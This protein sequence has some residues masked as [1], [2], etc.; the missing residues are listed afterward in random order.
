M[1]IPGHGPSPVGDLCMC[2]CPL[3]QVGITS[4]CASFAALRRASGA[5]PFAGASTTGWLTT[6][7]RPVA[8]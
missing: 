5:T 2:E 1:M 3:A 8:L 6:T 7:P 4:H